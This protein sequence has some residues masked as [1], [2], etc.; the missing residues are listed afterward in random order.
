M[1]VHGR[2]RAEDVRRGAAAGC[3]ARADAEAQEA[4]LRAACLVA[5]LRRVRCSSASGVGAQQPQRCECA[6][7]AHRG[8]RAASAVRSKHAAAAGKMRE[9][10]TD[11]RTCEGRG[12]MR[13]LAKILRV[14]KTRFWREERQKRSAHQ[15]ARWL[16]ANARAR[17]RL[18]RARPRLAPSV[19]KMSYNY[20]VTARPWLAGGACPA[21]APDART[22]AGAQ[23]NYGDAL[24]RRALHGRGR[25]ESHCRVCARPRAAACAAARSCLRRIGKAL[26]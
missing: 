16:P 17:R 8:A 6:H 1:R 4:Q 25:P 23:A 2:R 20:C 26:G 22:P 13:A 7:A 9:E 14:V 18:L 19:R 11:Q 24:G 21:R 15:Q 12:T 3:S 5:A 10:A